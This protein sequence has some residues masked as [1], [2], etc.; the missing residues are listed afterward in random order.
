MNSAS[1]YKSVKRRMMA[2]K[3]NA[4]PKAKP[5]DDG[6]LLKRRNPISTEGEGEDINAVIAEYIKAIRGLED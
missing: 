1:A 3:K 2:M 6:G 4:A 5:M